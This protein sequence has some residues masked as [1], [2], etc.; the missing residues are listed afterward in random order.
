MKRAF[1]VFLL[2]AIAYASTDPDHARAQI[3][4]HSYF[5]E[6]ERGATTCNSG[7]AAFQ[8]S[9]YPIVMKNC[10]QCHTASGPGPEFAT[11]D[12]DKSYDRLLTVVNFQDPDQS[13]LVAHVKS[14]HWTDY[15]GVVHVT[16]DQVKT[17][18]TAWWAN[19]QKDC[20]GVGKFFSDATTVPK[21]TQGPFLKMRFPLAGAGTSFANAIMELEITRFSPA[22]GGQPGTYQLRKP[23][24]ATRDVPIKIG[25]LKVLVNGVY[26]SYSD[27]FSE[28]DATV[29]P[30]DLPSDPATALPFPVLT[31]ENILLPEMDPGQD[32]FKLALDVL[33]VAPAQ[34]CHHLDLFQKNVMPVLDVRS[35]YLCHGGGP[36][37]YPGRG[38]AVQVMNMAMD[39][40]ALCASFLERAT[41]PEMLTSPLFAY[42]WKGAFNHPRAIA[43]PDEIFPLWTDW[44]S[45]EQARAPF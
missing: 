8:D 17:A 12:L 20:P 25:G 35:C 42:T 36:E 28:I 30:G 3:L 43:S 33:E 13:I 29:N 44:L 27:A 15:G 32:E 26:Y 18:L 34:T 4:S 10:T 40:N 41:G 19:G 14:Q 7:K 23:R 24:L 39:D 31:S 5:S 9:L 11:S 38:T 22:S 45:A 21:V 6:N 16:V 1:L 2:P 37:K